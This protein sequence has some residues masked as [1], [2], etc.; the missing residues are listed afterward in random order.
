MDKKNVFHNCLNNGIKINSVISSGI[1]YLDLF[2]K[3]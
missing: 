3:Q 1:F 2:Y